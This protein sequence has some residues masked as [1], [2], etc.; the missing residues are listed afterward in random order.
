LAL[1]GVET[2]N[3]LKKKKGLSSQKKE[4][5][6]E[7]GFSRPVRT[8]QNARMVGSSSLNEPP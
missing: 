3:D 5:T 4:Q 7:N 6:G 2:L 1:F 8:F